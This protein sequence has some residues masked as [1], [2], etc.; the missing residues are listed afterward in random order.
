MTSDNIDA[1]AQTEMLNPA[2]L[3]VVADMFGTLR[4]DSIPSSPNVTELDQR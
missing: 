1:F 4:K 3:R 2:D